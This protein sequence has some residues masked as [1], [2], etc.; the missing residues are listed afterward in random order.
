MLPETR[1]PAAVIRPGGAGNFEAYCVIFDASDDSDRF[2]PGPAISTIARC[3]HIS[4]IHAQTVCE[5][6]G[7]GGE[8]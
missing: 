5:L 7:I 4:L 8:A 1:S 3:F 6:A 2:G